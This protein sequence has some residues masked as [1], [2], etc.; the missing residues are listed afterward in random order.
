[1]IKSLFSSLLASSSLVM[2][3][4]KDLGRESEIFF[5]FSMLGISLNLSKLPI[6]T[7]IQYSQPLSG[8]FIN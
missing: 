1:M 2:A 3:E 5:P 6:Q 4:D 7:V 8:L